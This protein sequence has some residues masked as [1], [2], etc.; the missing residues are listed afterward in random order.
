MGEDKRKAKH[1]YEGGKRYKVYDTEDMPVSQVSDLLVPYTN[2]FRSPIAKL[3]AIRKG[4]QPGAINDLIEITGATQTDVSKWLDI[5]EPT[6]RKHIQNTRELN[7]G[8]SEHIIQLFELFDKG[9][10]T[11]G[12]LSEFKNWLKHYNTGID[13]T[14]YDILD[15]ITGIGIVMNELI[16]IDYGATA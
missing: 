8:L 1:I 14:P 15:T 9:L 6:L 12:S 7:L 13:A 16:R 2:Y 10:D 5:T 3:D 11:F 4:L